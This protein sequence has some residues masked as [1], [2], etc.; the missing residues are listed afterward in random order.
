MRSPPSATIVPVVFAGS[1]PEAA[2]GTAS[3]G[4]RLRGFAGGQPAPQHGSGQG[5]TKVAA[6]PVAIAVQGVAIGSSLYQHFSPMSSVLSMLRDRDIGE[7]DSAPFVVL[8]FSCFHWC[9]YGLLG[10]LLTGDQGSLVLVCANLLGSFL[11]LFYAESFRKV[12]QCKKSV[13]RLSTYWRLVAAVLAAEGVAGMLLHLSGGTLPLVGWVS[14]LLSVGVSVAPL[15]NLPTILRT[16]S[17]ESMPKQLVFASLAASS[18]WTLCGLTI[19]NSFVVA[20]NLVNIGIG[21]LNLGLLFRFRPRPQDAPD[22]KNVIE[23]A[24]RRVPSVRPAPATV[25]AALGRRPSK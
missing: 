12:C 4:P 8:A 18:I 19:G 3:K 21:C 11:G 1:Q 6:L 22:L 17:V 13:Q 23:A 16:G 5:R 25:V 9:L 20:T 15:A 7:R 2:F 10:W 14:T 24:S